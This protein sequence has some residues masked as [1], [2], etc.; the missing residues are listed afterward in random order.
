MAATRLCRACWKCATS[1][2]SGV[3]WSLRRP[4]EPGRRKRAIRKSPY[5]SSFHRDFRS[6]V[7][8]ALVEREGLH[9]EPSEV[10]SSFPRRGCA[11]GGGL[12]A[13]GLEA[14]LAPRPT[15]RTGGPVD[16]W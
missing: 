16:R 12:S 4:C 5:D 7:D 6:D 9:A 13:V 14:H 15:V 1:A 11:R 3:R 2:L 8:A 10:S